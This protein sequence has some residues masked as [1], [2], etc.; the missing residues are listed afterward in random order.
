MFLKKGVAMML[1]RDRLF[2]ALIALLIAAFVGGSLWALAEDEAVGGK[3]TAGIRVAADQKVAADSRVPAERRIVAEKTIEV[4]V[5]KVSGDKI[6]EEE[7]AEDKIANGTPEP[8]SLGERTPF[9]LASLRE[10]AP[11]QLPQIS[12][13]T[14]AS[15]ASDSTVA[16]E[17]KSELVTERYPSRALKIERQMVLDDESNY[18][19]HGL[20]KEYDSDGSLIR[21]GEYR[22]GKQEG[23]W[24]QYFKADEGCL[25]SGKLSSQF[26]GPFVSEAD[27]A[28]GKLH[29]TWTITS[30]AGRKV[31]EWQFERGVRQGRACWWHP[32]GE[33]RRD[34]KYERGVPVGTFEDRGSDGKMVRSVT[35]VDGRVLVKKIH[36][37]N[38]N[39]KAYEGTVLAGR[40]I[41]DESFDWWNTTVTT[42]LTS[43]SCPE[44]KH[45][46]WISWYP[47][48]QTKIEAQY[49]KGEPV[50]K[51]V[52]WY[53]NGQKQAQGEYAGGLRTGTW[54]TWH[55]NGMKE[56]FGEYA[57]GE[58][59]GRWAQWEPSGKLIRMCNSSEESSDQDAGV[60]SKDDVK[61]AAYFEHLDRLEQVAQA[62]MASADTE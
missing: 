50:G 44:Q 1:R 56:S 4:K 39:Q 24:I 26:P 5:L 57:D 7:V 49:R 60:A 58:I 27:F 3:I 32:N 61:K 12:E 8:T 11:T 53:E 33:R 38:K 6:V 34:G 22:M 10:T 48:G 9:S 52:W 46:R 45:G 29:G 37:H 16:E 17:Q 21:A 62:S 51:F 19:N 42:G 2:G 28:G 30:R 14:P 59:A 54:T 15:P 43:T 41:P 23:R 25:F 13:P 31:I 47:N 18:V 36:W 55:L 40:D 20:Y 35:F